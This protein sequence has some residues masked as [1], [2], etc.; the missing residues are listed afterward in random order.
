M[1][2]HISQA[3]L[4]ALADGELSPDQLAFVNDHLAACPACTSAAL[5]QTLLKANIAKAGQR[6]TMPAG[7]EERLKRLKERIKQ[8]P[9]A[10]VS[11]TDSIQAGNCETGTRTFAEK[12]FPDRVRVRLSELGPYL[13]HTEW[14]SE[15][16]NVVIHRLRQLNFADPLEEDPRL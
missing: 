16:Q 5:V 4:N 13:D 2:E 12:F 15:V 7:L 6:Y 14:G 8:H 9:D 11:K 10:V 1:T 3:D